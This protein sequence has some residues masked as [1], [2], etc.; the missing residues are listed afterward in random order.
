MKILGPPTTNLRLRKI[1][2]KLNGNH[3][4]MINI[5]KRHKYQ[6]F[7]LMNA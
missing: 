6:T 5:L 7:S 2:A 3:I 1:F 4:L